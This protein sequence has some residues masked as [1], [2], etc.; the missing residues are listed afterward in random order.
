MGFLSLCVTALCSF[1]A[2]FIIAKFIGHNQLAQLAFFDCQPLR[3]P[4]T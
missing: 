1:G 4:H 3:H 2:R